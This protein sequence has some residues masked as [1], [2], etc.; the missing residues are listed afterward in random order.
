[1]TDH[2]PD[3]SSLMSCAW[4]RGGPR[5]RGLGV[6]R[7]G[8]RIEDNEAGGLGKKQVDVDGAGGY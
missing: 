2:Q 4:T 7:D 8:E 5:I 3:R 6:V 1:M